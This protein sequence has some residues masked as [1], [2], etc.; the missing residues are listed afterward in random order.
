MVKSH[1]LERMVHDIQWLLKDDGAPNS[2]LA[3]AVYLW[4]NKLGTVENGKQ[5]HEGTG[6]CS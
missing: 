6:D 2:E 1:I 3:N 4:D 5:Y